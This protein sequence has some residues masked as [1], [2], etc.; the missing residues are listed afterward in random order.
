V[1]EETPAAGGI[2]DADH[3]AVS[4]AGSSAPMGVF[5]SL[6]APIP[7]TAS[8]RGALRAPAESPELVR[9]A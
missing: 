5:A 8:T 7:P 9:V 2:H 3:A 4:T 1:V 6:G